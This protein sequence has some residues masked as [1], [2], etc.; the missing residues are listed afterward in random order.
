MELP[1]NLLM[2]HLGANVTLPTMVV[3]WGIVCACQ[4]TGCAFFPVSS[5]FAL[6]TPSRFRCRAL[7][8]ESSRLSFLPRRSRRYEVLIPA[9]P[10]LILLTSYF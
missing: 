5:F 10:H 3:L 9:D 2:K 7:L 8:Q 1:M 4:G 6:T